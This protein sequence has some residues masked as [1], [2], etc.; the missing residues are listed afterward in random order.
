MKTVSVLMTSKE[1]T[2][3]MLDELESATHT[4]YWCYHIDE[5]DI[6]MSRVASDILGV[7]ENTAPSEYF[8]FYHKDDQQLVK[9]AFDECIE[10]GKEYRLNARIIKK[11]RPITY[12][13]I[14]GKALGESHQVRS[15]FGTI[16]DITKDVLLVHQK[17]KHLR[18]YDELIKSINYC[19]IVAET[20]AQ[21]RITSVNKKFCEISLFP[22]SD[23]SEIFKTY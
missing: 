12:V 11:D 17:N 2:E 14:H 7:D 22:D 8:D 4:G 21:G 5:M 9:R 15:V 6:N 3:L 10:Y 19:F 13:E 18:L 16:K 20:D 23:S 1:F